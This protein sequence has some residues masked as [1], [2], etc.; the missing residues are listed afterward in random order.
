M[1]ETPQ[2]I[3]D[4][5]PTPQEPA[6]PPT[7]P[8]PIEPTSPDLPPAEPKKSQ[9]ST[10]AILIIIIAVSAYIA[11]ASQMNLWPFSSDVMVESPTPTP[12][13]TAN[14]KTYRND[15]FEFELKHPLALKI[16]NPTTDSG[17]VTNMFSVA[18]NFSFVVHEDIKIDEYW[19]KLFRA[20]ERPDNAL[21]QPIVIDNQNGYKWENIKGP[22]PD[23]Q[24]TV[25]IVNKNNRLFAFTYAINKEGKL[26]DD[27]IDQI[28]FDQILSTF[29]FIE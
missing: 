29:K 7:Q 28:V 21:R 13:V 5:Q 19:T 9:F 22:L 6:V 27:E 15:E 3:P 20:E 12:E 1:N 16:A 26:K 14:W 11:L 17:P 8:Q 10:V 4:L 25:V 23:Y 2:Q 24:Y 18:F